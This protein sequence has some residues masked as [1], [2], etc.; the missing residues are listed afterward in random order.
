MQVSTGPATTPA[1]AAR[2]RGKLDSELDPA[3][4]R[5]LGDPTRALLFGCL[6]KCGRPCTVGELAECCA[7]D[8]S[9]VSR[10]LAHLAQAGVLKPDRRGRSVAYAVRTDALVRRF[11]ALADGLQ[12]CGAGAAP[13]CCD[14]VGPVGPDAPTTARPPAAPSARRRIQSSPRPSGGSK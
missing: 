4:F 9:V 7:V 2:R 13:G 3:L 14:P 12:S 10:H 11:R 1:E 5:A 6:V 8:L